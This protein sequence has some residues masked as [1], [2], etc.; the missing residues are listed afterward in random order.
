M[1][2][3]KHVQQPRLLASRAAGTS[4]LAASYFA[5]TSLSCDH[6]LRIEDYLSYCVSNYH[7]Q[8]NALAGVI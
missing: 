7:I 8:T 1:N 5:P 3:V 6:I 4:P 2:N